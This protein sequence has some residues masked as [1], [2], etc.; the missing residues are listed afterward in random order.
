MRLVRQ[1]FS[2]IPDLIAMVLRSHDIYVLKDP[3]ECQNKRSFFQRRLEPLSF[4]LLEKF[5]LFSIQ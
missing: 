1:S 5:L 4:Q 2:V 3:I